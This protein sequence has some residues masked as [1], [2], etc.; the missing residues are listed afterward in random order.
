LIKYDKLKDKDILVNF[1]NDLYE[2]LFIGFNDYWN[3][4]TNYDF[5]NFNT[6]FQKYINE[7]SMNLI[8]FELNKV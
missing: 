6:M 8:N 4:Q 2:I 7:R 3:L 1:L 5:M